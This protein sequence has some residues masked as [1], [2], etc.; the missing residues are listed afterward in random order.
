MVHRKTHNIKF[1]AWTS[2]YWWIITGY[3]MQSCNKNLIIL[4]LIHTYRYWHFK[5]V[6]P[7]G[8]AS[9]LYYK[10][11][12]VNTTVENKH[13]LETFHLKQVFRF[14][15]LVFYQAVGDFDSCVTHVRWWVWTLWTLIGLHNQRNLVWPFKSVLG[16]NQSQCRKY[17]IREWFLTNFAE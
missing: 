15:K 6:V 2:S 9:W 17:R 1:C 14:Q 5:Q 8:L 13:T 10:K 11:K 3:T 4:Q 7:I 12:T 16:N